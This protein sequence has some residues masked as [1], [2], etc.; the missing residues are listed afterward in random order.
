MGS[1][2]EAGQYLTSLAK[3]A[4]TQS[5]GTPGGMAPERI[6]AA[7]IQKLH[8]QPAT[9]LSSS[10]VIRNLT[11]AERRGAA[12]VTELRAASA[13][14]QAQ[15]LQMI[16]CTSPAFDSDTAQAAYVMVLNG[17]WSF[18]IPAR[19]SVETDDRR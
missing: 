5:I 11:E 9:Q 10:E 3:Q 8:G 13:T 7:I 14:R 6:R 17:A 18:G 12:L 16:D 19:S 2:G 4:V 1:T 15:V